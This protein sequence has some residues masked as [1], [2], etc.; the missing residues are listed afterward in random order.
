MVTVTN[1]MV[2]VTNIIYLLLLP[3]ELSTEHATYYVACSVDI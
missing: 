2:T 1:I 3:T